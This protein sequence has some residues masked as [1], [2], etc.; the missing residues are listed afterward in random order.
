VRGFLPF[1]EPREVFDEL[2]PHLE[3]L[4]LVQ[5]IERHEE[6]FGDCGS[7]LELILDGRRYE[8]VGRAD[9]LHLLINLVRVDSYMEL[10]D[11]LVEQH[12]A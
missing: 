3:D 4:I 7:L 12:I 5:V 1:A 2:D 11:G 10:F 6:Q 9:A 8:N